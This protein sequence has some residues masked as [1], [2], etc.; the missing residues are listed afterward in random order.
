MDKTNFK[1]SYE[2]LI[3]VLIVGI[4]GFLA[5]GYESILY[6][7]TTM[8]K[9]II[10]LSSAIAILSISYVTRIKLIYNKQLPVKFMILSLILL[11]F[12]LLFTLL[13]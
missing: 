6:T 11:T 2:A 10:G 3:D 1:A 12:L 4:A 9:F 8:Q 5:V 7:T 13:I